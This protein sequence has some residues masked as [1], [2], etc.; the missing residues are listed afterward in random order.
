MR[1][2]KGGAMA[3]TRTWLGIAGATA[4]SLVLVACGATVVDDSSGA[5]G[6]GGSGGTIG[7][8][9]SSEGRG[10]SGGN[11]CA[12]DS[13]SGPSTTTSTGTS[14]STASGTAGGGGGDFCGGLPGAL[15]P[16]N[17]FCAFPNGRCGG[18]DDG[19][20]CRPIPTTC[21]GPDSQVCGCD[22]KVY[23][24]ACDAQKAGIDVSAD[25]S[26]LSLCDGNCD[27]SKQYC[28]IETQNGV[29]FGYNCLEFPHA[30]QGQPSCDCIHSCGACSESSNGQITVTC[31]ED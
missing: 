9:T 1:L 22:G 14:I 16:T 15:C 29:P 20:V 19:G 5:G 26:C 2:A 24:S 27:F 23:D 18:D 30:C 21:S 8:G 13:C 6:S 11:P 12:P 25:M 10:G 7:T 28:R 17:Q 3:S 4:L 31:D